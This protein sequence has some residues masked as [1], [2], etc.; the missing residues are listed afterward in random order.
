VSLFRGC[1]AVIGRALSWRNPDSTM[2]RPAVAGP[3][4]V[5]PLP[6]PWGR[7]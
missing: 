3:S 2:A 1:G 7:L 5:W 6:L 4:L